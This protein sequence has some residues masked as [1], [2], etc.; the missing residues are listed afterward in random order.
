RCIDPG[1]ENDFRLGASSAAPSPPRRARRA[2]GTPAPGLLIFITLPRPYGPGLTHA[3]PPALVNRH[4]QLR[5]GAIDLQVTL[6]VKSNDLCLPPCLCASVVGFRS[7]LI[8]VN[9]RLNQINSFL[10]DE[11]LHALDELCRRHRAFRLLLA[12][13]THVDRTGLG[14]LL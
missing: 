7:A 9:L 6:G 4:V 11:L 3:A 10:G 14:F 12:A 1:L 13:D 2:P 8:C 5:R